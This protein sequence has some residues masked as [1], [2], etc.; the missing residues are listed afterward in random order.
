MISSL[1]IYCFKNREI[2]LDLFKVPDISARAKDV[3]SELKIDLAPSFKSVS[4]LKNRA[5]FIGKL[6]KTLK[7]LK[8][9]VCK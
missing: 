2:E 4:P 7:R 3:L 5:Q 8:I 6:F 1:Q 9:I